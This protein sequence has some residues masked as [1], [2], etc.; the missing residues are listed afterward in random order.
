MGIIKD[1]KETVAEVF[2]GKSPKDN[3]KASPIP[4]HLKKNKKI[5]I[6]TE[7]GT[8]DLEF[9]YPYYRFSEEGYEVDVITINGEAFS[10]KKG[11]G[12]S[13]SKSIKEVNPN[14]YELVYIPGGK[15]PEKLRKDTDVIKFVQDF[16]KKGKYIAAICHG[17]QVLIS[18]GLLSGKKIACWPEMKEEL[19]LVNATFADEALQEDGQFI[20]A[21]KPGDLPRH[22]YGVLEK[23]RGA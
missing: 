14:D 2:D 6:L 22:L 5:A 9:F 3:H 17:P 12:L 4:N 11:I 8:E 18:A 10:G 16:A 1:V 20:T 15:A 13:C 21:R 7:E 19:E 23:L